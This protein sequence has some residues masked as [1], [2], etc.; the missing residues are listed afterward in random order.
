MNNNQTTQ[1]CV[2]VPKHVEME[3]YDQLP[4]E[5]RY[6]LSYSPCKVSATQCLSFIADYPLASI[7]RGIDDI[8]DK[9]YGETKTFYPP[10]FAAADYQ[11]R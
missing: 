3:A 6:Q 5:L 4:V 1:P 9:F 8:V 7:A 2:S 10:A 11:Q